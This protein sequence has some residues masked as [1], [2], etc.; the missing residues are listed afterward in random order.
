MTNTSSATTSEL[1]E[2][3]KRLGVSLA[4]GDK[5]EL[6]STTIVPVAIAGFGFGAGEGS[7]RIGKVDDDGELGSGSGSGGGGSAIPIGAYVSDEFGTRFQPNI[8]ALL[9][10]VLPLALVAGLALPKIIKAVK[11]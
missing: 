6:G 4:Y 8:I 5:V 10:A 9:V 7:G 3:I 2:N 11:R 1:V